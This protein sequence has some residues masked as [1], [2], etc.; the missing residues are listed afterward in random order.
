[1]IAL[2]VCIA[3]GI[4]YLLV[5]EKYTRLRRLAEISFAVGLAFT[6]YFYGGKSVY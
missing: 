5:D 6:L 1:M 3:G 2:I 4:I